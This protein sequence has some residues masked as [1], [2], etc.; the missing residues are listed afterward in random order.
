MDLCETDFIA[1]KQNF[2]GTS[3]DDCNGYFPNDAAINK[4][5]QSDSELSPNTI[6]V[7]HV[8]V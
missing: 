3:G 5:S 1:T 2:K 8:V 4:I 6:N 7:H